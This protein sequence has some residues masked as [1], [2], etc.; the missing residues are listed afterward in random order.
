MSLNHVITKKTHKKHPR[1]CTCPCERFTYFI[2][3]LDFCY[4]NQYWKW[5]NIKFMRCVLSPI[6]TCP[7]L[8]LLF[9]FLSFFRC[10]FHSSISTNTLIGTKYIIY[11]Y[12]KIIYVV[13]NKRVMTWLVMVNILY[14]GVLFFFFFE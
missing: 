2:V 7:S 6:D 8:F 3:R 5:N 11:N 14:S 13:L 1:A 12:I 10:F 4:Y 9:S